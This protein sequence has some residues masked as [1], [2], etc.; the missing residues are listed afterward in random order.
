[1]SSTP[2]N[3]PHGIDLPRAPGLTVVVRGH[4][5]AVAALHA[6]L[7][8]SWTPDTLAKEVHLSRSQLVRG[9]T[10]HGSNVVSSDWFGCSVAARPRL[11]IGS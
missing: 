10:P 3:R 5:A 8:Q 1:M 2:T 11:P 4:V 6:R 9:L 7:A